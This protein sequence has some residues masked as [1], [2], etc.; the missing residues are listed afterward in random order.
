[1]RYLF[2]VLL[3]GYLLLA[4]IAWW[5]H[6]EL[7]KDRIALAAANDRADKGEKVAHQNA[8]AVDGLS[9]ALGD[10]NMQIFLSAQAN[11]KARKAQAEA[12]GAIDNRLAKQLAE[13]TA[14]AGGSCKAW[15]QSPACGVG[16]L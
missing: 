14:S 13:A 7:T 3:G 15:A 11:D 2:A 16:K 5:Q 12:H 4:G 10:C 6:G 8:Q 9:K 1:M